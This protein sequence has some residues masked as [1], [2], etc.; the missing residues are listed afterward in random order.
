[1]YLTD[2]VFLYRVTGFVANGMD[3]TA[4][5]EVEDCYGLDVVKVS[6]NDV[7]ARRLRLVTPAAAD[8]QLS[9][10]PARHPSY[11]ARPPARGG[12]GFRAC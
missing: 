12:S 5:L 11:E 10:G 9:A 4:T 1:M 8:A 6:I 3:A 2:G 7:E